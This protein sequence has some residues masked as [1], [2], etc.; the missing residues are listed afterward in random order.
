[1]IRIRNKI[2]GCLFAVAICFPC[3]GRSDTGSNDTLYGC[4]LPAVREEGFYAIDLPWQA[5]GRARPDRADFRIVDS[6]GREVAYWM[7]ADKDTVSTPEFISY[8]MNVRVA[9]ADTE[10]EVQ[11]GGRAVSSLVFRIKN[12]E[13]E[14][15]AILRGSNDRLTWYVVKD[16]FALR[17]YYKPSQTETELR[18]D[19]PLS[20]YA[21]YR[22]WVD[23]SV[24]SPLNFLQAGRTGESFAVQGRRWQVP[25]MDCRITDRDYETEILLAYP[26]KYD[27]SRIELYVSGPKY[28]R[29][30]YRF[31][32]WQA[33]SATPGNKP[34]A[35]SASDFPDVPKPDDPAIA[36]GNGPVAVLPVHRYTD[37]LKIYV[38]NG[39]DLPLRIDSVRSCI[40]RYYLVAYLYPGKVYT[41]TFG[42]KMRMAP[43]YDL[44]FAAYVPADLPHLTTG[45][46]EVVSAGMREAAPA[47][48]KYFLL[49]YGIWIVIGA[50]I[51]QL[52]YFV[53]K[54]MR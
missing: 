14:K 44:S 21:Y 2:I 18:I 36:S 52:L 10:V 53:W 6:A 54:M 51:L 49:T 25:A 39:D 27:F 15:K 38:Y 1:M 50:V 48:W 32:P 41:L 8:P 26:Y 16:R 35:P 45:E 17:P 11:T 33:V 19:F 5:I 12:A 30:A 9:G 37:S 31:Y 28:Y 47:S 34:D 42:D 24:S 4:R 13:T 29:R 43:V 20:D 46:I 22:L 23:D 40:D 3:P 7:K